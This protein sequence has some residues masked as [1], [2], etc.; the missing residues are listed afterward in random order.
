M[1][2]HS[3]SQFGGPPALA[4]NVV[5]QGEEKVVQNRICGRSSMAERQP[6]KLNVEGSSPFARFERKFRRNRHLR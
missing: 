6:S 5:H 3:L 1:A 2:V 4:S